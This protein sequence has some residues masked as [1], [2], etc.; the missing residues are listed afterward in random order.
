MQ[1][2]MPENKQEIKA[3]HPWFIFRQALGMSFAN[4]KKFAVTY[5]ILALPVALMGIIT[6][7]DFFKASGLAGKAVY[8]G[9]LLSGYIMQLWL[10]AAMLV[11]ARQA[12]GD[13]VPAGAAHNIFMSA[14]RLIPFVGVSLLVFILAFGIAFIGAGIT[15]AL[16]FA[17]LKHNIYMVL[18]LG[19]T[20]ATPFIFALVYFIIRFSLGGTVCVVENR[21]IVASI[22]RSR[23]LINSH[24]APVVGLY[25]LLLLFALCTAMLLTVCVSPLAVMLKA[26]NVKL[27]LALAEL[28][29]FGINLFFAPACACAL[30]LL[31]NYLIGAENKDVHA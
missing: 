29:Q 1:I 23:E 31:F 25:A 20:V 7:P 24:T 27:Q 15:A 3:I 17:L 18:T 13:A 22:K 19:L 2:I 16:M 9:L 14:K 4:F 8:F 11:I 12:A 30:I 6:G 5:C 26:P 28:L 10:F 21:G